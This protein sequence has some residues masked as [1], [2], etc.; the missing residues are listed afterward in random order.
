MI[1]ALTVMGVPE[2]DMRWQSGVMGVPITFLD[3]Y[4][5]EQFSLIKFRKGDDGQDLS[6]NGKCPYFRVLIQSR[7]D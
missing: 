1:R 3:K 5:P 7:K 2:E 4:D 6:V